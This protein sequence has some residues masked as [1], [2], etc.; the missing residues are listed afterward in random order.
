MYK[1]YTLTIDN[2]TKL[3]WLALMLHWLSDGTK[4]IDLLK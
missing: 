2:I 1:I 4:L 3:V